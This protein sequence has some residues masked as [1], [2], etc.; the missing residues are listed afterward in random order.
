MNIS[1]NRHLNSKNLTLKELLSKKKTS[2]INGVDNTKELLEFGGICYALDEII[3]RMIENLQQ[4]DKYIHRILE[5]KE[6]I[7]ESFK[8]V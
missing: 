7:N 1:I 4:K 5:E 8:V 6:V 3:Q 2:S